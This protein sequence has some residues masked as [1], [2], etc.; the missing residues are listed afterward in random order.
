MW[1]LFWVLDCAGR[2][3]YACTV[4]ARASPACQKA[5]P[6][7]PAPQAHKVLYFL[8]L[9]HVRLV[10][11]PWREYCK[12]QAPVHAQPRPR[13]MSSRGDLAVRL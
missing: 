2:Y 7:T 12:T 1:C 10:P 11:L 9:C 8:S 3:L 4:P 5:R 13:D 6:A